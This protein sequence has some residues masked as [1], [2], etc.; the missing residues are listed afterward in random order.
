MV[1]GSPVPPSERCAVIR[2]VSSLR[3]AFVTSAPPLV[4]AAAFTRFA[5]GCEREETTDLDGDKGLEVEVE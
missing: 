2:F 1:A 5:V 4:A 3:S